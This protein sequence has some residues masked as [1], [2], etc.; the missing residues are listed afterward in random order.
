MYI[1]KSL[2]H[3]EFEPYRMEFI[4]AT[5]ITTKLFC[6]TDVQVAIIMPN[7]STEV[8]VSI[9]EKVLLSLIE[10]RAITAL[11]KKVPQPTGQR[12]PVRPLIV[13]T[14]L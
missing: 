12:I 5:C 8:H 1:K 13:S 2:L 14:F 11:S 10:S 3:N 7:I 6:G 4:Q 9:M